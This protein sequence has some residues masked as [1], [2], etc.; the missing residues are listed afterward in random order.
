MRNFL[1]SCRRHFVVAGAFSFFINL[2]LLAV[3]LY[4]L[5]VFD[6]VFTS[7]SGETLLLLTV[8]TVMVLGAMAALDVFRARLLLAAGVVLDRALGPRV[9]A[10]LIEEA[11]LG[12]GGG[13]DFGLR[14]VATLRGYLT[15]P[16]V[17]ALF[18][19][20]WAP[21]FTLLVFLFHPL[22]GTIAVLGA[23][24]LLVLAW[25]NDRS[26]RGPTETMGI[27][28]RSASRF[29][30]ASVRNAEA[31]RALGMT[32]PVTE[33]WFEQNDGVIAAQVV[34]GRRAALFMG[35][36]RFLR[37][38]IQV[39]AL[40]TGAWLVIRHEITS[41]AMIAT[42][43]LLARALGPVEAAIGTWRGL[44]DAR[45]ARQRLK[46]LLDR[47]PEEVSAGVALPAPEG[48]VVAENVVLTLVR[49][50]QPVLK[51]VSFALDAGDTVGVIGPSG[52]GKSSL[53]RVLTGVWTPTAGVARLDGADVATWDRS[54]LSDYLGYLPQAV[55]LFPGTVGENI[56]RLQR[57]PDERV[58]LAAQR[59]CCHDMILRLPKGYETEVGEGGCLLPAGQRQR[60]AL[61]RALF[62]DPRL[63]VLDE[64]NSNLDG[65]GEEALVQ[66]LARL[67]QDGV[68]VVIVSHKPSLLS[69]ADK[70]LVLSAGRVEMFG[71]RSEVM[72]RV[73]RGG[74]LQVAKPQVVS[75]AGD[76]S[77][78]RQ[79]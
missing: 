31:V 43:L 71:P 75:A 20:P 68:T 53:A 39:A 63:V 60:I 77:A 4:T 67:K 47:Q 14:D 62:G 59:A 54:R 10:R 51:G 35:L 7:R 41:G 64:P 33:R 78:S 30:N 26:T 70:L 44:Q 11:P 45:S 38:F 3:P 55:E 16:G 79:A 8:L 65:E 58:V 21:A 49:G 19:A 50:E 22:L 23:G 74:G 36:T 28:A 13:G 37:L 18:D 52:A 29:I 42:T 34:V 24:S 25:L 12:G 66:A 2:F 69:G 17:I 1:D 73:T 5:Q 56:A 61:A 27:R 32:A 6:R 46:A 76:G 40:G 9:I 72:T 15:G 57:A 48:R